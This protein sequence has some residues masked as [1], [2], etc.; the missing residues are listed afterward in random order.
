MDGMGTRW[1][2]G[3]MDRQ[4]ALNLSSKLHLYTPWGQK[5][6]SSLIAISPVPNAL[7]CTQQFLKKYLLNKRGTKRKYLT[8]S[9]PAPNN[10]KHRHS[11][12]IQ[13]LTQV[14]GFPGGSDGEESACSAGDLGS[15]SGS[16]RSPGEGNGYP[17]Q[18]SCLENPKDRGAWWA[19]ESNMTER[20]T[21]SVTLVSQLL[22]QLLLIMRKIRRPAPSRLIFAH[23]AHISWECLEVKQAL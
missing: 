15:I 21:L 10:K 6:L 19:T 12:F 5:L 17:L 22:C 14:W 7:P 8:S 2:D 18:Y 13:I 20:L 16:G 11:E 3:Q 23:T 1:M 4:T 9:L